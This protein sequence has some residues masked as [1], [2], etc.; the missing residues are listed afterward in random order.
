MCIFFMEGIKETQRRITQCGKVWHRYKKRG[1]L[2]MSF[3]AATAPN[4][5]RP[6]Q[7]GPARNLPLD[8]NCLQPFH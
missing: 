3:T 4:A 1:N 2:S 7:F 8:T 5:S 6:L